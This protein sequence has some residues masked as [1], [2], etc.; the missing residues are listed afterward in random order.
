[1]VGAAARAAAVLLIRG[2]RLFVSP[3]FPR[4]CRFHPSCSEYAEEALRE[5]GLLAGA[6]LSVRRVLRCHP[7]SAGGYDPVPLKERSRRDGGD[8]RVA[9]AETTKLSGAEGGARCPG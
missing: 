1:M 9:A 4:A 2:Y 8:G 3:L 7:W 6:G 5:H